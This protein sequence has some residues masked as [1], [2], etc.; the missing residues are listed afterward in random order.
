MQALARYFGDTDLYIAGPGDDWP[1]KDHAFYAGGNRPQASGAAQR[2]HPGSA[3][4]AGLAIEDAGGKSWLGTIDAV[5]RAGIPT[6][7]PIRFVVS[8]VTRRST[9]AAGGPAGEAGSISRRTRWPSRSFPAAVAPRIRPE[10]LLF[11]I[12]ARAETWGMAVARGGSVRNARRLE[13]LPARFDLQA[14]RSVRGG[15]TGLRTGVRPLGRQVGLERA[16]AGG[17]NLLVME[18]TADA[19]FGLRLHEQSQRQAFI[20]SPAPSL[21][22]PV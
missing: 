20:S 21:C 18:Q 1:S 14:Y 8:E 5:A 16:V 2:S 12:R 10:R 22:W 15:T 11:T 19:V 9:L 3:V 4:P 6:M 17:L 13:S 7:Y